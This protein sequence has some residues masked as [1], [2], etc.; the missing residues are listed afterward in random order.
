M[1]TVLGS[2]KRLLIAATI[3]LVALGGVGGGVYAAFGGA[4]QSQSLSSSAIN[5][6]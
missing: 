2:R 3:A 5:L 1:T 4:G 6:D